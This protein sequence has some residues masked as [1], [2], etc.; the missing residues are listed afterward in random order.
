MG[1]NIIQFI[2]K[3]GVEALMNIKGFIKG[4]RYKLTIF[5]K[6]LDWE[7]NFWPLTKYLKKKGKTHRQGFS[8]A[9]F[10]SAGN[11]TNM[12]AMSQPY[13]DFAKAYMRYCYGLDKKENH[14][15][16]LAA[17]R[18][19]E[20]I[21]AEDAPDGIPKIERTTPNVLNKAAQALKKKNPG[22]AFQSGCH[23]EK[24]AKFL[25]DN[26]M[27]TVRFSWVN[28][29]NRKR[30]IGIRVGEEFDNKRREKLPS[31]AAMRALPLI[32]HAAINPVDV[33][34]T[35]M[36]AIF[37][38]APDRFS[39]VFILPKNCEHEGFD[40]D[41]NAAYGLRWN[42]SKGGEGSINWIVSSM[43]E[44]CKEALGK[45]RKQTEEA[46]QIAKWYENNPDK[47]YLPRDLE[48]LR[49]QENLSTDDLK[50][51]LG[52]GCCWQWAEDHGI[53]KIKAFTS[54]NGKRRLTNSYSFQDVERAI[55]SMLP[56]GFPVLD[57]KSGLKY[58]E[59][60]LI[61]PYNLLHPGRGIYQCM[62][63]LISVNTFNDQIGAG[64][65][66]GKSSIF[67]RHGHTEPDGSPIELTSHKFRHFLTTLALKKKLSYVIA[68][69]WR[70]SKDMKQT[71][72]Y[73]HRTNEEL[74][75]RLREATPDPIVEQKLNVP[76]SREEFM[77]M[78]YPCVH[79]TQFGFCVHDWHMLP[80]QKH[81]NCLA[82]TEHI[83]IKGDKQKT[84]RTR[85]EL[86]DAEAQ[87]ERDE[88]AIARGELGT[89]RWVGINRQRVERLRQLVDILD[90]P[91]VP[92]GQI[93]CVRP[94]WA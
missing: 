61:I 39:E 50:S 80:C 92:E 76:V 56:N 1:N 49:H 10:D 52:F 9:N 54:K 91:A 64:V 40:K 73:D 27:V 62:F 33:I 35:S 30:D 87:L 60:L 2:P 12:V 85:Q 84:E 66:H 16:K 29:I 15:Q 58:S 6:D 22:S 82:C 7:K 44:T 3:T 57:E 79:A 43:V 8:F 28:P 14:A 78:M 71:M 42:A 46:R 48:Y 18:A 63:Q 32:Y 17:V 37:L 86:K 75:E 74:V 83:C 23:L 90:D 89:D 94:S 36:S 31:K 67:S 93:I 77:E 11:K 4:C 47:L 68:T 20:K 59:A 81:S 19:L 51:L 34:I 55:I 5:G 13:L 41:N 69:L 88:A 24:L 21:L 38:S 53:E 45:L 70:K 65:V 25:C 26:F 72:S